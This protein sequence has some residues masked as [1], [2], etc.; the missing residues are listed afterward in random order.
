MWCLSIEKDDGLRLRFCFH[1]L[2]LPSNPHMPYIFCITVHMGLPLFQ[3]FE[4]RRMRLYRMFFD[5]MKIS[6]VTLKFELNPI[7][8]YT[9]QQL[10]FIFFSFHQ[11]QRYCPVSSEVQPFFKPL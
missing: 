2:R 9:V 6:A 4:F 10:Y 8:E 1:I 3:Y 5:A 11:F 7:C